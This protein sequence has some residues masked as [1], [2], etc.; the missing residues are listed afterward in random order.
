MTMVWGLTAIEFRV[1]KH[2]EISA[3]EEEKQYEKNYV[4]MHTNIHA[5][6]YTYTYQ[7]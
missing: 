6:I 1:I 7:I 4:Y 2:S 5:Y 3:R